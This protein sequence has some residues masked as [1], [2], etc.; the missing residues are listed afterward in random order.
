MGTVP[1]TWALS[2]PPQVALCVFGGLGL[3][4]GGVAAWKVYRRRRREEEARGN[5]RRVEQ[6]REDRV[7]RGPR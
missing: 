1:A 7:N 4:V 5:Q 6:I 3:V 2:L